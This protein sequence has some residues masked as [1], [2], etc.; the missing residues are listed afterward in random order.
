MILWTSAGLNFSSLTVIPVQLRIFFVVGSY[1]R[2]PTYTT[3]PGTRFGF[4]RLVTLR[5]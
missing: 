4:S 2:S 5:A 3:C 1:T